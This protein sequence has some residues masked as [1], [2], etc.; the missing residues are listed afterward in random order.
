MPRKK[1]TREQLHDWLEREFRASAAELCTSCRVP[2]P[3]L[4]EGAA[5]ANWRLPATGECPGLCHT[6]L[7]EIVARAAERYD[8]K[9]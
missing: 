4:R 2:M 3:V 5:G 9:S 1:M 7:E 8:L 6:V